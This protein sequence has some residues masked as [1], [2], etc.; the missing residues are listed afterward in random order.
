MYSWARLAGALLGFCIATLAPAER[1][2]AQGPPTEMPAYQ[3]QRVRLGP[4]DCTLQI[5]RTALT[6]SEE[7][8]LTIT[9]DGPGP[10]DINVPVP[11]AN[12]TDWRLQPLRPETRTPMVGREQWTLVVRVEPFRAGDRVALALA[13]IRIRAANEIREWTL[14]WEPLFIRVTTSVPGPDLGFAKPVVPPDPLSIAPATVPWYWRGLAVFIVAAVLSAAGLLFWRLTRARG[15]PVSPLQVVLGRFERLQAQAG[16]DPQP[17]AE[18]AHLLRWYFEQQFSLHTTRMTTAEIVAVVSRAQILPDAR[19]TDLEM[20][21]AQADLAK[22]AGA[23]PNAEEGR[24]L[25]QKSRAIVLATVLPSETIV[26][27]SSQT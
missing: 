27:I 20:V 24:H 17:A 9:V 13:P 16:I 6:L 23:V 8:T 4:M 2:A 10:L 12:S 11:L 3:Q 26:P 1:L 7:L 15:T 25:L 18:L 19:L 5:S 21:L 22:F 14:D